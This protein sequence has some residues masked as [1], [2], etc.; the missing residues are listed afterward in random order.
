MARKRLAS[1]LHLLTVREVQ[2]APEGDHSD[3][4]G[5][6]LRVRGE[7]ASCVLRYTAESGRRR[8]MGLGL[9]R[10]GS[11]AQAGDSITGV[12]KEAQKARELLLEG[13]DPIDERDRRREAA[14][15]AETE[16]KMVKARERLTLARVARDYHER[17]VEP[18][19][20]AKHGAQWIASLENHV[21]ASVWHAPIADVTA[22]ML[23][24]ALSGVRVLDDKSEHV[25]RLCSASASDST[26][27]SKTRSSTAVA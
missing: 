15:L 6:L 9:A 16:T 8:E 23:L 24:Q 19:L 20:T 22:P 12:R 27:S 1:R 25:P 13:V 17:A 4:G 11:P 10:R 2:T 26:P 7:S 5:L 18:R 3:G 21:P 14:K